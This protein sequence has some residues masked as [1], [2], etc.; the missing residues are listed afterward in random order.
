MNPLFLVPFVLVPMLNATIAWYLTS[1]HLLD[2]IVILVPWS[3][4][5]PIGAAWASNG[6]IT[7]ALMVLLAIANSYFIYL[8]F[9]KT[10]EKILIEQEKERGK[11]KFNRNS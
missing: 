10:H 5:A 3:V 8:P 11:T 1:A 2:R 7:N 6:S 9:F 4:P